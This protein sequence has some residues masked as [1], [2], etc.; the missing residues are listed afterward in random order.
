MTASLSPK[1]PATFDQARITVLLASLLVALGSGTNYVPYGPQ[2]GAKLGISHTQLNLVGIGGNVGVNL[3]GPIWGRIVDAR[4][5]KLL[6][7][8]GLALLFM[9]YSGIRWIYDAGLPKD[10][11]ELSNLA[12]ASLIACSFMTGLGGNGG[13]TA[14]TN[15]TARTFPDKVRASTI[16]LVKSGFGLSAFLFSTIAHIAF[17][18]NTSS[19]LFLLSLGTSFPMLVGIFLVHP[20]PPVSSDTYH[21]I[22]HASPSVHD[23]DIQMHPTAHRSETLEGDLGHRQPS[24][25]ADGYFRG[26]QGGHAIELGSPQV[27][28]SPHVSG[29]ALN[30]Y[31]V[32]L[33]KSI[34]F[35]IPFATMSLLSG[36]GLMYINN[37]GSMAQALYTYRNVDRYD[38]IDASQWQAK[39]VSTISLMNFSGRILIGL[40]S[41]FI[42]SR[43]GLPRS[44]LLILVAFI[45]LCSQVASAYIE[46]VS[47]LWRAS[48]L[49][50]LG[51]GGMF[52]LFATLCIEWYGLPHFSENW[53]YLSLSPLIG[54][55]IFSLAFGRNIDA[56]QRTD[57]GYMP[58]PAKIP[59][60]Q[61][62]EGLACYVDSIYLTIGACTCAIALS[63]WTA[64]R[65]RRKQAEAGRVG[66]YSRLEVI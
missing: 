7:V 63:I 13:L 62:L 27:L 24:M 55:N 14:A 42:K 26:V 15:T 17:P 39:Q 59:A 56:H 66:G 51:Y 29:P 3:S 25:P 5:P 49:L 23:D 8:A 57:T 22:D 30:I 36:S 52:S 32:R 44:T 4:G 35:W 28:R 21:E 9:G 45:L 19:F 34:D 48:A 31:G 53:G 10:A 43:F 40:L 12:I 1:T 50:G 61:C 65:D 11:T 64:W 2:L 41:D 46:D 37:V 6:M 38:A 60:R 54:A 33:W 18:G 47:I 16:G 58:P 20:I